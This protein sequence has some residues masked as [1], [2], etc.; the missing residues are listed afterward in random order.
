MQ[1][2]RMKKHRSAKFHLFVSAEKIGRSDFC[3][4]GFEISRGQKIANIEDRK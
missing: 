4:H 3:S 2:K 1:G